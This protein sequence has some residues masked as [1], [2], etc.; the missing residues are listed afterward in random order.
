M[1]RAWVGFNFSH[2]LGV[3]LFGVVCIATSFILGTTVLPAWVLFVLVA[4]ALIYLVVGILYWFRI[5]VAGITLA[6]VCLFIAWFMYSTAG[7]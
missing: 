4:I 1:W 7:V 2:S 5:P 3:L 6:A